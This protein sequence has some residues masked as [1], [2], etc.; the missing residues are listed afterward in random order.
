M[1]YTFFG[2]HDTPVSIQ[3]TLEA[4]IRNLLNN[5]PHP[6]FYIGTHGSFDSM[7]LETVRKMKPFYPQM[8]YAVVLSRIPGQNTAFNPFFDCETLVPDGIEST[9]PRFAIIKRNKWM[10]SKADIVI[11][12]VT[13]GLGNAYKLNEAARKRRKQVYNLAQLYSSIPS[14]AQATE[15]MGE[16]ERN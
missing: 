13:H 16:S 1:I 6:L 10:L 12:Y 4:L 11:T 7:A 9:P 3:S 5:D 14:S 8:K 2:H 15:M